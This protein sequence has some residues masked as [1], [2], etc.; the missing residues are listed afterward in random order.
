MAIFRAKSPE[1]RRFFILIPPKNSPFPTFLGR[2]LG[3]NR[4]LNRQ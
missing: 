4:P 3:R 2:N 1:N